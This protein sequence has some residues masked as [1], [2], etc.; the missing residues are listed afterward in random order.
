[1]KLSV[2]TKILS[3]Y[4]VLITLFLLILFSGFSQLKRIASRLDLI[5]LRYLPIVKAVNSI[6]NFYHLNES[7]DVQKIIMNRSN[8]LFRESITISNPRLVEQNFNK[9]LEDFESIKKTKDSKLSNSSSIRISELMK[10]LL[11]KH[12]RYTKTIQ[13]VFN[14]VGKDDIKQASKLN[15]QLT[16]EK[17]LVRTQIDFLSRQLDEL[18]RQSIQDTVRDERRTV[19]LI[20]G[21]SIITFI[22]AI[23]IGLTA[24]FSLRPLEK[25]KTVAREIAA[26]DLNQR[27]N[28]RTNDEVGD[29]SREF[30]RM[31]DSIQQRDEMLRKQQ[32]QLIQAEKMAV[33]GRMASQISHEIRN[34]LN[35]LS[36]NIEMLGD[37]AQSQEAK[38]T[39][40]A[41]S[42]E[43]DR[44]NRIAEN[45]LTLAR[46]PKLNAEKADLSKILAHLETLVKPECEKRKINMEINS[47]SSLPLVS[48]DVLGFEQALLNLAKNAMDA[49]EEGGKF[50]IKVDQSDRHLVLHVWDTGAGIPREDLPHIFEPFYTTKE[51]GTGLGLAITHEI[52][53]N[54][55]GHIECESEIG[56]GT[57]FFIRIPIS[58]NT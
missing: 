28:I 54:Q 50:G 9:F 8:R 32:E 37:E 14:Y 36:L 18:I 39:I 23:I 49:L 21:L 35:A 29:L 46:R 3:A 1:M 22:V 56:K 20:L 15:T 27:V 41:I 51:K 16:L 31:A 57:S 5:Q 25:L 44:L 11:E 6:S 43:I 52:I 53:R 30:N 48:I 40:S 4:G 58:N 2:R 10:E 55:G 24:I 19:F 12:G 13:T 26:G 42:T 7:F 45:Y 34:P 33:I 47:S 17:H 38:K